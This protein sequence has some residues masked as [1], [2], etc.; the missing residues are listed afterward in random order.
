M[1]PRTPAEELQL[2]S[3]A[4][5]GDEA[6]WTA[7]VEASFDIVWVTARRHV[8]GNR[9]LAEEVVQEA[10]MT[11]V[12]KLARFDPARGPFVAWVCGLARQHAR[13]ARRRT[14]RAELRLRPLTV[15]LVELTEAATPRA[16]SEALT[17][18]WAALPERD[19]R[20]LRARFEEQRSIAEI[21]AA[22][23]ASEKAIESLLGRARERF[24]RLWLREEQR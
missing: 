1:S 6:A 19:Q 10:W 11:A 3:A 13:N 4:L 17:R 22:F 24:R 8:R 21:A 16:S 9:S 12:K 18:V 2:R 23:S 15:E 5:R 14:A 20:V 7:L